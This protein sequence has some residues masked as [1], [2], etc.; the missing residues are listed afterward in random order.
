MVRGHFTEGRGWLERVQERSS[1]AAPA[2][3][4][5]AFTGAG[6]MA[7]SQGNYQ[8]A[9][10]WHQQAL[11]LYREVGDKQGIAFALNNLGIQAQYQGDYESARAFL[12]E[13]QA[14]YRELGDKWG[15]AIVL[16]NLGLGEASKGNYERARALF[17]EELALFRE[18]KAKVEIAL[19]LHNLGDVARYQGDNR[20]A[21]AYLEECLS[22]CEELG[23][24]RLTSM[25]LNILGLIARWQGNFARSAALHIESLALSRELGEKLCIAQSLEGLAGVYGMQKNPEQSARLLGAAE[26]V[27]EAINAPLSPID[28]ADYDRIVGTARAQLDEAAFAVAWAEGRILTPEQAFTAQGPATLPQPIPREAASSPAIVPPPTYPDGLTAREV[29]VL[30]L[31]AQ[32]LTNEQVAEKLVISP[33]TVNTHLTSIYGKI[34]VSSRSAAT[35][36]AIDHKFV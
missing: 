4:A 24:K 6:S 17:E 36:Y 15:I 23:D 12:E 10:R 34:G 7:W 35:R 20:R 33:R 30:R 3:Q 26:A 22:V 31:V 28:R 16:G 2:L 1:D 14:L 29:E 19:A 11:A 9:M 27:R 5:R 21:M 18:L 8:Q 32:G 13:S 25:T